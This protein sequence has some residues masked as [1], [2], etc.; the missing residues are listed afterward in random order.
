MSPFG[1]RFGTR[2]RLRG[3]AP[4]AG[5]RGR[6]KLAHQGPS[7]LLLHRRFLLR[8]RGPG[9][10]LATRPFHRSRPSPGGRSSALS[11]PPA[12][13]PKGRQSRRGAQIICA[14]PEC[15]FPVPRPRPSSRCGGIA[16]THHP[17]PLGR[18]GNS[19]APPVGSRARR[20]VLA[21]ERI[22]ARWGLA[23]QFGPTRGISRWSRWTQ[24]RP[25][26]DDAGAPTVATLRSV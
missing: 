9:R 6:V 7:R 10:S 24:R 14:P 1:T 21:V 17:T 18:R 8:C 4:R 5:Q 15:D 16:L 26:G 11:A 19:G 22:W 12:D 13:A 20:A 23:E 3:L 25:R 2:P